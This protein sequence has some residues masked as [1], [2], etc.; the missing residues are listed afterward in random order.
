[1]SERDT[2]GWMLLGAVFGVLFVVLNLVNFVFVGGDGARDLVAMGLGGLLA[3]VALAR[4]RGWR[5]LGR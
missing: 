1:V 4:Y 2:R 3:A 5:G